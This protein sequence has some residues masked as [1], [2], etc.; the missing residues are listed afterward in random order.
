MADGNWVP[1]SVPEIFTKVRGEVAESSGDVVIIRASGEEVIAEKGTKLYLNDTLSSHNDSAVI[2]IVGDKG[3]LTLGQEQQIPFTQAFFDRL[4]SL[5]QVGSLEEAVSIEALEQAIAEGRSLEDLLEATAAGGEPNPDGSSDNVIFYQRVGDSLIPVSGFQT[6]TLGSDSLFSE[7]QVG[8]S[9]A[10]NNLNQSFSPVANSSSLPTSQGVPLS[11]SVT[12]TDED[13]TIVSFNLVEGVSSG[14]LSFNLDGTFTFDP[15]TTFDSLGEGETETVTFTYTATDDEGNVSEP[16]T[17]SIVVTGTNDTPVAN[18]DNANTPEDLPYTFTPE[19]LLGNDSDLDGDSLTINNVSNATNGTVVLNEDGSV[20]FTPDPDYFGPA[21][22]EYTVSDGQGGTDTATVSIEVT[23]VNDAPV[24]VDDVA[25]TD[26]NTA[27]N[28]INLL[29]NDTDVDNDNSELTVTSATLIDPA[30]GTLTLNGD[31]TV[32]FV[33]AT[34]L[35]GP[36]EIAYTIVDPEGLTADGSLTIN[37][38]GNNLPDGADSSA[39]ISEDGS[40]TLVVSDFGFSDPDADQSFINVRIDTLPSA[41][42]LTVDGNPIFEGQVISVTDIAAGNLVIAPASNE[43]GLPYS[44]FSFSVQDS[45][46]GFD[47]TPNTFT[48]NVNPINDAPVVSNNAITVNEESIDTSLGLV[49][50]SDADGDSLTIT[51]TGLPALGTVTLADGSP[52]TNGQVLTPAELAGLQYDAPVEYDG[53]ADPGEFT[54]SVDDGQGLANSIATGVVDISINA[55]NDAPVAGDDIVSTPINVAVSNIN[56]LS[57]DSDADNSLAEL[58]VSAPT[59]SDPSQGTVTLNADGTLNFTP[60]TDFSGIAEITYT[61]TDPDGLSDTATVSV[62]VGSNTLPESADGSATIIEDASYILENSDFSF[63]D[64]DAGQTLDGVRVDSLPAAGILSLNGSPV[65]VG[66]IISITDIEAGNLVISPTADENGAPYSSFTFSIQDSSGAFDATPNTFTL[67]VSAV[68]DAPVAGDDS[69]TTPEDT[70]ATYTV[71]DLVTPNDSDADGDTLTITA[72]DNPTNGTVVLNADGSVTFTPATNFNGVASFEYTISDGNGGEDTATVTVDVTPVNDAPI[73]VDDAID[74]VEDTPITLGLAEIVTPNDTDLDG[75]TLTISAVSD[76]VNGSVV[77]NTDGT[78]TFT[79]ATDFTGTASF[80]YTITD[81]NGGTDTATVTLTVAELDDPTVTNPDTNSVL[82]DGVLSVDGA[83]GVLANDSDADDTLSVASYTIAGDTT[84]YLAGAPATIPGVGS[85]QLDADGGYSFTPVA[86]YDGAVPVIT[87]TTNTGASDTLT[88]S[89]TPVN[90]APINS[91]PSS[92]GADEDTVLVFT[93]ADTISV[94]D[95]DGNLASTQLT[96]ENGTLTVTLQGGATISS[97]ANGSSSLT[98]SGSEADINATLADLSYIGDPDFNGTDTLTIVS[99]DSGSTPLSDTDTVT[100]TVAE[101]GAPVILTT[102]GSIVTSETT[103][104]QEFTGE[105][106]PLTPGT[107]P[108]DANGTDPANLTLVRDSNVTVSFVEETAGF[109][110]SI[111]YYLVDPEGNISNAQIMWA[112]GND[113]VAGVNDVITLSGLP[114]GEIGFFIVQNGYSLHADILDDLAS[115]V[116]VLRF[117]NTAGEPLT[118]SDAG[119]SLVYYSAGTEESPAGTRTELNDTYH[120]SYSQF[121]PDGFVH[122]RS[123]IDAGDNGVLTI[124]FEDLP[125]TT[126]DWDIQDFVMNVEIDSVTYNVTPIDPDIQI[127]D[128]GTQLAGATVSLTIGRDTDELVLPDAAETIAEGY[129]ISY[130]YDAQTHTMT[131]SGTADLAEYEEIL[132]AVQL[133]SIDAL[134]S[135]PRAIEYTVTDTDG[136][137]SAPS[138]TNLNGDPSTYDF[139]GNDFLSGGDADDTLSGLAGDDIIFGNG[140][141]DTVSGGTGSDTFIWQSGDGDGSTD[142][143]SDFI[144]GTGGDVLDFSDL[145]S[146]EGADGSSLSSFLSVSFDGT[147]S[148]ITVDEDGVGGDTD[149]TVVLEGINLTDLGATQADILQQLLDDGNLQVGT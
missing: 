106:I 92:I 134:G 18:D 11:S 85:F 105:D 24:A 56:V 64:P 95:I 96:V 74:A 6:S 109:A 97:G 128:D 38:G 61:L 28:N 21:S 121:I 43:S 17:V 133:G 140:G 142:T 130:V 114:A 99:T 54:Y 110:N 45:F 14:T 62:N 139:S 8:D 10:N 82:E 87:Y 98:I 79:P 5:E 141:S 36:V 76:P 135:D 108:D 49:A 72:V 122:T 91:A 127:T 22:F 4:D 37:V 23:P 27:I 75:D 149:L 84:S 20:T 66:Q 144:A 111:G 138:V 59:L 51:V 143:I 26:I 100:I 120:A 88:L 148:T 86:D 52:V 136:L 50:P 83:G 57:N 117:E 77:L 125:G 129:G 47:A 71:A 126:S 137:T 68:N 63:T 131:F 90:D 146:G 9:D 81:G 80:D 103:I 101:E 113:V 123:G 35:T 67:N 107:G 41:G 124:G 89:I 12:A 33:P 102:D 44:D 132:E 112:D 70:A 34:N 15:G 16:A 55:I 147:N 31:G 30:Q 7:N 58:T 2:V 116:G 3:A 46:G 73:A 94:S 145:L 40:Y 29:A 53:V 115:G 119:A 78:V 48:L 93:G 104:D 1:S 25:A 60:A 13:G 19:Q 32:D 65:S 69:L 39:T 42:T 118:T